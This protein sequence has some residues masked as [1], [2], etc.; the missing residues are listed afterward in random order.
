MNLST[1]HILSIP[2]GRINEDRAGARGNMAWIIDGATDLGD[3]AI[4]GRHSDAA[5]LADHIDRSL[6]KSAANVE[7]D[8]GDLL[9]L[10]TNSAATAFSNDCR[11]T[12]ADTFEHPSAA[13]IIA[14]LRGGRFEFLS[15]GDCTLLVAHADGA[16]TRAG[17][18]REDAGDAKLAPVLQAAAGTG[19]DLNAVERR[20]RLMP[21]LR[22]A[23]NMMNRPDG[24][25]IF[26]ITLPPEA[27]VVRGGFDVT[28]GTRLMLASDG[29]M[30]LVDLY[31]RYDDR[32]LMA[33]VL[34]KGPEPLLAEL[35]TIEAGDAGAD[36]YLRAKSSDDASVLIAS[37]VA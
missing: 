25:G 18:A 3:E 1:D 24:Y 28:P 16:V 27:L 21:Y 32:S 17:V 36:R 33:A 9:A 20:A 7:A 12:P 15:L 13:G 31:G 6:R 22:A 19:G 23:R 11:R 34:G 29:F 14:R 2:S 8:L 30:R 26:S 37:V 5:W 4:V 10:V 35:R